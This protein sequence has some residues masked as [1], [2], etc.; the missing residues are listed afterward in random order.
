MGADYSRLGGTTAPSLLVALFGA[1][2]KA[3]SRRSI[4]SANIVVASWY[5]RINANANPHVRT[6]TFMSLRAA[7]HL[8]T[9]FPYPSTQLAKPRITPP[10]GTLP[11]Q[12][13]AA[14]RTAPFAAL[15]RE[16]ER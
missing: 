6:S 9:F 7:R 1:S 16:R 12:L 4:F 15:R 5:A 2:L 13:Y 11:D 3:A 10:A 8:R 14:G